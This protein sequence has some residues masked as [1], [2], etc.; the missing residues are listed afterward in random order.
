MVIRLQGL[1]VTRWLVPLL[2]AALLPLNA[3][4]DA[5]ANTRDPVVKQERDLGL[6]GDVLI[7]C[8]ANDRCTYLDLQRPFSNEE[9][10]PELEKMAATGNPEATFR[11]GVIKY[12]IEPSKD[13]GRT[14]IQ[15]AATAG[16][17]RAQNY[18]AYIC[19]RDKN[20]PV[21]AEEWWRKARA[22]FARDAGTGDLDAMFLLGIAAPPPEVKDIQDFPPLAKDQAMKWLEAA[23]KAGH[24]DACFRLAKLLGEDAASKASQEESWKW[25]IKAV[26]AGYKKALVD[27]GILYEYGYSKWKPAYLGKNHLKAWEMWD[28][29]ILIMGE[30]EFYAALPL[31][32]EELPPRSKK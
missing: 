22:S 3:A 11:L 18:W 26:D 2:L 6:N 7:K 23:A 14:L 17:A 8:R 13:V 24:L 28:R 19:L 32:K 30:S 12:G 9:L 16:S 10:Q 29:A 27:V 31:S 21:S 1:L 5:I 4:Q 25:Y 15:K 20:D